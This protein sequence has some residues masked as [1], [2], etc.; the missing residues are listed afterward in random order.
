MQ[1]RWYV[2]AS[3]AVF[4]SDALVARHHKS[5]APA[6]DTPRDAPEAKQ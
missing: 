2:S 4:L 1:P 3:A 6:V 5:L